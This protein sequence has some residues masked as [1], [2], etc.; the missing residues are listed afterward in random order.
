MVNEYVGRFAPS[1]TGLLH[2]GSLAAA[3]AS[4]IDAK[5]HNGRWLIRIEDV[6]QTRCKKEWAEGI[7]EVLRRLEMTGDGEI[8]WQSRRTDRYAEVLDRLIAEKKVYGCSCSRHSIEQVVSQG[9]GARL[10]TEFFMLLI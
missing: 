3:L 10:F 6:D 9:P 5:A 2:A 1:P 7:L 4:F 8:I